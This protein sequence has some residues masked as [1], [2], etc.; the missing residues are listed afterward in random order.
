MA[1][2]LDAGSI[3]RTN[4]PEIANSARLN[5]ERRQRRPEYASRPVVNVHPFLTD[6]ICIEGRYASAVRRRSGPWNLRDNKCPDI[7]GRLFESTRPAGASNTAVSMPSM[8]LKSPVGDTAGQKPRKRNRASALFFGNGN[9]LTE[10]QPSTSHSPSSTLPPVYQLDNNSFLHLFQAGNTY[11]SSKLSKLRT[12]K[13]CSE[14]PASPTKGTNIASTSTLFSPVS[15]LTPCDVPWAAD[16]AYANL[17]PTALDIRTTRLGVPTSPSTSS[18]SSRGNNDHAGFSSSASQSSQSSIA[19]DVEVPGPLAIRG[20]RAGYSAKPKTRG[21]DYE[22]LEA[23]TKHTTFS[24]NAFLDFRNRDK[25][26]PAEPLLDIDSPLF[27]MTSRCMPKY[28][29]T[30]PVSN[31]V[32]E[33]RVRRTPS[34]SKKLRPTS[35][36]SPKCRGA[37]LGQALVLH[38][39]GVNIQEPRAMRSTRVNRRYTGEVYELAAILPD[40]SG[41]G[42]KANPA[43]YHANMHEGDFFAHTR[44]PLSP[45][46]FDPTFTDPTIPSVFSQSIQ[47]VHGSASSMR[48]SHNKDVNTVDS[49]ST[50]CDRIGAHFDDQIIYNIMSRLDVRDLLSATRV[51]RGFQN[52]FKNH[53]LTLSKSA[54]RLTSPAAWEYLEE[55]RRDWTVPSAYL[56]AYRR[57]T[58]TITELRTTLL[59]RCDALLRQDTVTGLIRADKVK[60]GE[61][62]Q[63]FWRIWTFCDIFGHGRLHLDP[64]QMQTKWFQSKRVSHTWPGGKILSTAELLDIDEIWT[65]LASLLEGFHIQFSEAHAVGL[66]DKCEPD[67]SRLQDRY[68]HKWTA[69]VM[70]FG[71]S[72]ILELSACSFDD[73]KALG[74]TRWL[75]AENTMNEATFLKDAVIAAYERRVLEEA[76]AKAAAIDLPRKAS[77]RARVSKKHYVD[78]GKEL[79]IQT[80][81]L[82]RKAI[83]SPARKPSLLGHQYSAIQETQHDA[84][85][86]IPE[87]PL[88]SE[89]AQ[90]R[91]LEGDRQRS[92]TSPI[93]SPNMFQ[94]LSLQAGASTQIGPTL[95]PSTRFSR[96]S[97]SAPLQ[98]G[99]P[100]R[101]ASV[102]AIPNG[103]ARPAYIARPSQCSSTQ[104][105]PNTQVQPRYVSLQQPAL[106]TSYPVVDPLDKAIVLLVND[107]GFS[108]IAAKAALA[109]C[110][111]GIRFDIE[112][113]IAILLSENTVQSEPRLRINTTTI[114]IPS[115]PA[116]LDSTPIERHAP[117]LPLPSKFQTQPPPQR[118]ELISPKHKKADLPAYA[119]QSRL[120][121]FAERKR[122][123]KKVNGPEGLTS[124]RASRLPM[125][126]AYKILGINEQ[127][128]RTSAMADGRWN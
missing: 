65:C 114:P 11:T 40:P 26:L 20:K 21:L 96:R 110:D 128:R 122:E 93:V 43:P 70:T 16:N 28:R 36:K 126:K 123:L 58:E 118:K 88:S 108:P 62:D 15:P 73:A 105:T 5:P 47:Q 74:W 107:M 115:E 37:R 71:P 90:V 46:D 112:R 48:M 104:L 19:D 51:S 49:V 79:R 39:Q 102:Q 29:Y 82:P 41:E 33:G 85:S 17:L 72:A 59:I 97:F 61:I 127:E 78:G 22:G 53:I 68:L 27:E 35:P 7:Q 64:A 87:L 84:C 125:A 117:P 94:A 44:L 77:G 45:E 56:Q 1:N 116:E 80:Q 24:K 25:P 38:A 76:E 106:E 66:F 92:T 103:P 12:L 121:D 54:L 89:V 63:A 52:V 95:F 111:N 34:A 4:W 99:R 120:L 91:S 55:P 31:K 75:P 86:S 81:N 124:P 57:A 23:V 101:P 69:H 32:N 60:S 113:A 14:L 9:D 42:S 67:D 8:H 2:N 119:T 13:A 10:S 18:Q 98:T 30:H 100:N 6:S 3:S 83:G 109:S 50:G